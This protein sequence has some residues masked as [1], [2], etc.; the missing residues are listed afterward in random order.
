MG[1]RNQRVI[2]D[3]LRAIARELGIPDK[4][5]PARPQPAAAK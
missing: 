4:R 5:L 1:P 3:Q 2:Q